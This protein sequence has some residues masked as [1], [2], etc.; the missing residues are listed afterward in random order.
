M[1]PHPDYADDEKR[2][3]PRLPVE[4]LVP[5]STVDFPGYL[6]AVVFLRG[7]PWKC[8]YCHNPHLRGSG[9]GSMGWPDV[10]MLLERRADLLDAIV[11]S[12]G[13]PTLHADLPAA[14]EEARGLGYKI[15]LHTSGSHPGALPKVLPLV[16]WV[17]L[18]IK[19]PLDERYDRI[20]GRPGSAR[21][22]R[23]SLRL[24]LASNAEVQLR[25][26]VDPNVFEE[27]WLDEIDAK[28]AFRGQPAT[29]RQE[30]RPPPTL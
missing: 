24:V 29:V 4:G 21:P 18:D 25:T 5:F 7:C 26:T 6:A 20:T 12:G 3:E 10:R 9:P 30:M 23:E 28:L 13:E 17:G 2:A 22:L 14:M 19:A 15:G 1:R 8:T 11:F 16:D 27:D